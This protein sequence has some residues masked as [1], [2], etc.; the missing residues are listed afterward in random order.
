[1]DPIS[2][3]EG[4]RIIIGF[5]PMYPPFEIGRHSNIQR[6]VGVICHYVYVT[7]FFHWFLMPSRGQ[8]ASL[9]LKRAPSQ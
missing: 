1:M 4:P 7:S 2:R 5:M 3:S 9:A 8:I 6:G